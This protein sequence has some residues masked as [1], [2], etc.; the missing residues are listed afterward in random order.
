MERERERA[1]KGEWVNVF[2][3]DRERERGRERERE[4]GRGRERERFASRPLTLQMQCIIS[5]FA[6][7]CN[8][9]RECKSWVKGWI[10]DGV[11]H[12]AAAPAIGRHDEW[13]KWG[14]WRVE[15]IRSSDR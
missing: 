10:V 1:R 15:T 9:E 8:R 14:E 6:D 11:P 2:E 12:G 5:S 13:G 3:R 4:R 7:T